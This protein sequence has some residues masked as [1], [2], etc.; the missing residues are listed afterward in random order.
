MGIEI[1]YQKRTTG[2]IDM[3]AAMRW[4]RRTVLASVILL[5]GM[6]AVAL[7]KDSRMNAAIADAQAGAEAAKRQE[8]DTAIGLYTKA[9]DADTLEPDALADTFQARAI[10]YLQKKEFELAARDFDAVIKRRP[11]DPVAY[12]GLGLSQS[13]LGHDEAALPA[14]DRVIALNQ[15]P[16][17][18]LPDSLIERGGIYIDLGQY[19]RAIQDFDQALSLRPDDPPAH[20][21]KGDAEF[22]AGR[23]SEAEDDLRTASDHDPKMAYYPLWLDMAMSRQGKDGGAELAER[24]AKLDLTAWPGP[25]VQFYLGRATAEDMLTTARSG[26]AKTQADQQCEAS[27]YLGEHSLL[28]GD[29]AEAERLLGEALEHCNRKFIEYAGA[30]AEMGRLDR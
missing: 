19:D 4:V 24:A 30:K 8:F 29:K 18:I 23:F 22:D 27:F 10:A 26:D 21:A 3:N 5:A 28:A 7:V 25:V 14:L 2:V 16:Y 20:G 15:N 11:D 9:I 13:G 12:W 1:A 17:E 6:A